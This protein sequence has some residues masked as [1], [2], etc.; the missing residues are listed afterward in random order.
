[1]AM[2]PPGPSWQN[3]IDAQAP[4]QGRR[5]GG[6]EIWRGAADPMLGAGFGSVPCSNLDDVSDAVSDAVSETASEN[7]KKSKH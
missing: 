3:S 6:P 4:V 7:W 2:D 1:M 5:I